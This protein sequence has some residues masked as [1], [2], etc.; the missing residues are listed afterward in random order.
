MHGINGVMKS[1]AVVNYYLCDSARRGAGCR[2]RK[3]VRQQ[4]ILH[5]VIETI[6][7]RFSD[8][9]A[10]DVLRQEITRLAG[11]CHEEVAAERLRLQRRLQELVKDI[12]QGTSNLARLPADLIDDVVLKVREWQAEKN[13]VARKLE[14]LDGNAEL[15]EDMANRIEKAVQQVGR[16]HEAVR[17]ESPGVRAALSAVVGSVVVHIRPAERTKDMEVTG[18]EVRMADGLV[19]LFATPT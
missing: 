12:S 11:Q 15:Q 14:Q 13:E 8:G 17:D 16:L 5:E 19:S 9:R 6:R 1:G 2:A 4:H 18:I 3:Y 7:E 10:L